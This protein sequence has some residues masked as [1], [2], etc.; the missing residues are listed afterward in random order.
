MPTIG[1][2]SP[3]EGIGR[4]AIGPS[5]PRAAEASRGSAPESNA[6]AAAATARR[7]ERSTSRINDGPDD[8]RRIQPNPADARQVDVPIAF[9]QSVPEPENGRKKI[10]APRH[11]GNARGLVADP[12]GP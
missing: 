2:R 7:R 8:H 3:L 5:A 12:D 6:P 9:L 11:H 4:V 10:G 1:R